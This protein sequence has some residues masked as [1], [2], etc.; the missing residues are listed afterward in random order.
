M[1]IYTY[2]CKDCE[3]E[4]E[5]RQR[6][7]DDPLTFC[8]RCDGEVRRVLNSVGVVFKG[9]G[10]YITDSRG[11]KNAALRA[12][13]GKDES[14]TTGNSEAAPTTGETSKSEAATPET[15]KKTETATA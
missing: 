12:N 7:S 10:F 3:H 8:P 2:R 5:V 11:G 13:N 1:P 4:F 14:T 15:P 6:M 9:S